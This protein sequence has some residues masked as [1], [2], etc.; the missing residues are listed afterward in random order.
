MIDP[1]FRS[2]NIHQQDVKLFSEL[3]PNLSELKRHPLVYH[4]PLLNR[5]PK[6]QPGIYTI[7]GGRQIGKTTV[8]KQWMADLLASGV[9]P[10]TITYLT[11]ELVDD[12]HS[13][14]RLVSQ[15][16]A[17]HKV[18][19]PFY[20]LLDEITYVKDWEKGIKFL[21][22]AGIL[23]NTVLILT[24]SDS[25]I[26]REA[27]MR[28]PGRR[29]RSAVID[30]HLFPLSFFEFVKLALNIDQNEIEEAPHRTVNSDLAERLDAAFGSYLLHGGYLTAIND[31]ESDGRIHLST[32]NTYTDWIRGDVLKHGKQERF[33][34]EICDGIIKRYGTQISWNSLAK[35]LS[36]DH[37]ATVADYI[38]LLSGMDVLFV[39]PALQEDRLSGAPKK[40]R[41]VLFNDPFIFHS[42]RSWLQPTG[43]P[44]QELVRAFLADPASTGRLVEACAVSHYARFYP[45]YYIKAEGE[46]DIAYISKGRFWPLEIKWTGQMRSKDLKQVSK[47]KNSRIATRAGAQKRIHGIPTEPLV[48]LLFRLGPS[49]YTL[50]HRV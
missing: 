20:C 12:H 3:D 9:D 44:F 35:D 36:I 16:T 39:Q 4:F 31:V 40:A 23:R 19:C 45:T 22:D 25:M 1:R 41:K 37:P 13:L 2:H 15:I 43:D 32:F 10:N 47:Y 26:I 27:R 34:M 28:L 14:V 5:L 7:T 46:V 24:G 11:G 30:F 50:P 18:Q 21:A 8:L 48:S 49:P 17:E 42:L 38:E 33:L 29:G 6:D